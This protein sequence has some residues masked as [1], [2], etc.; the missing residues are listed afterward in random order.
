[1]NPETHD[2][3]NVF[4]ELPYSGYLWRALNLTKWFSF[5]IG[6]Y[7]FGDLNASVI[8]AHYASLQSLPNSIFTKFSKS[9]N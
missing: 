6:K 5:R 2:C 8:D 7:K 1:M 9:P 4:R 3:K